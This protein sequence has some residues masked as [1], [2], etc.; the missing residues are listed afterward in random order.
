M[1]SLNANIPRYFVQHHLG[2]HELGIFSAI[3]YFSLAGNTM[4]CALGNSVNAR[5]ARS[6]ARGLQRDFNRVLLS[7]VAASA[8]VGLAGVILSAIAGRQLLTIFY[9]P[10]YGDQAYVLTWLM[11][12]A[13]IGFV[14]QALIYGM[15]AARRIR[16][17]IPLF[18]FSAVLLT[19][20]CAVL[21]P[22]AGL[23]GAA[24]AMIFANFALLAGS[25]WVITDACRRSRATVI[26]NS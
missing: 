2:E 19:V 20:I 17:Q 9:R 22:I 7:Y 11:V 18:G 16:I 14:A 8:L 23:R 24:G 4:I 15:T 12:A 25:A 21:I 13:G 1:V 26:S 10:E 5:M 3:A 6:Y